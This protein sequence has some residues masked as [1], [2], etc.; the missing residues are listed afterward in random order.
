MY[1]SERYK[2]LIERA[3]QKA[4]KRI[5]EYVDEAFHQGDSPRLYGVRTWKQLVRA[6]VEFE[7]GTPMMRDQLPIKDYLTYKAA[8]R[9]VPPSG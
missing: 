3:P 5:A 2:D 1:P 6:L 9:E 4:R 7:S 8:T